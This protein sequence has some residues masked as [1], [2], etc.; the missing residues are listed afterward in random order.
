M[1]K[2][3]IFCIAMNHAISKMECVPN[4]RSEC[5]ECTEVQEC[6]PHSIDFYPDDMARDDLISVKCPMGDFNEP[7]L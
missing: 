4:S 5:N 6:N 7:D 3:K 2:Y 1:S